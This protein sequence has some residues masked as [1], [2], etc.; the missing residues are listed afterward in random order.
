MLFSNTYPFFYAKVVAKIDLV[1][2]PA[3]LKIE[4]V[5]NAR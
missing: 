3:E 4:L 1:L 2:K 5:T